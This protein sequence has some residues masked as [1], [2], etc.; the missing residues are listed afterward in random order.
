MKEFQK[1]FNGIMYA[2]MGSAVPIAIGYDFHDWRWWYLVVP[3]V[4]FV[5]LRD[6][7]ER[8]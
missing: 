7:I 6:L 3:V 2:I 5:F 8:R 1:I 4:Y